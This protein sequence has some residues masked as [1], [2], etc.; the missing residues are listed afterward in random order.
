VIAHSSSFRGF[1][2]PNVIRVERD[3]APSRPRSDGAQNATLCS[4]GEDVLKG[5][6]GEDEQPVTERDTLTEATCVQERRARVTIE[7]HPLICSRGG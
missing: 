3:S 2:D 5:V 7:K 1:K 6:D 4:K